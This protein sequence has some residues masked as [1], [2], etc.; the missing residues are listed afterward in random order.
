MSITHAWLSTQ[1]YY[2]LAGLYGTAQVQAPE[3]GSNDTQ[4]TYVVL[5]YWNEKVRSF[6]RAYITKFNEENSSNSVSASF[7]WDEGSSSLLL[8]LTNYR[9]PFLYHPA[10]YDSQNLTL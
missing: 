3:D 5:A 8:F 1:I 9:R 2:A 4:S 6:V 7:A 10:G